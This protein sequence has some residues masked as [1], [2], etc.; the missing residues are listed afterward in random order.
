MNLVSTA[1][2]CLL[3][4]RSWKSGYVCKGLVGSDPDRLVERLLLRAADIDFTYLDRRQ[5]GQS[6]LTRMQHD[7]RRSWLRPTIQVAGLRRAFPK[8]DAHVGSDDP[9]HNRQ[10]E[11]NGWEVDNADKTA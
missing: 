7:E 2:T 9:D 6:R 10:F 8:A 5:R 3:C 11:T 1:A 4:P